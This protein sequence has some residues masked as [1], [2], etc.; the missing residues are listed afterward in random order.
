MRRKEWNFVAFV[1]VDFES[2]RNRSVSFIISLLH[3]VFLESS[4]ENKKLL[5]WYD[6]RHWIICESVPVKSFET[7]GYSH[8]YGPPYLH[9][10]FLFPGINNN[11][12]V[13]M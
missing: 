2:K 11:N 4:G 6:H 12:I 10:F 13:V 9:T 7:H 1:F 3:A 5:L 8:L